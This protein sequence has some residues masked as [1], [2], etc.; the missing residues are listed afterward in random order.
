MSM[1]VRG[2]TK[3]QAEQNGFIGDGSVLDAEQI[4]ELLKGVETDNGAARA[5]TGVAS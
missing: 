4:Q 2:F 1:L 3:E 5:A